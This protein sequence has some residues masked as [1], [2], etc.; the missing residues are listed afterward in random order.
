M[1]DWFI[2]GFAAAI[3]DCRSELIDRA[4]FGRELFDAA[5]SCAQEPPEPVEPAKPEPERE[6]IH[7][8]G[9]DL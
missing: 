2:E 8:H 4:W 9:I 1:P 7:E 6:T 3:N 5:G